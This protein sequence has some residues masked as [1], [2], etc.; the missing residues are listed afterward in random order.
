MRSSYTCATVPR[1]YLAPARRRLSS[2]RR[3]LHL[4][5]PGAASPCV[6]RSCPHAPHS[7]SL[8]LSRRV[9]EAQSSSGMRAA[10][11][12]VSSS[13][14]LR[15]LGVRLHPG[16]RVVVEQGAARL[17]PFAAARPP[18]VV[19]PGFP[20]AGSARCSGCPAGRCHAE[21]VG[22]DH[23]GA[24]AAHEGILASA[25][26]RR[27]GGRGR[28]ALLGLLGKPAVHCLGAFTV[29]SNTLRRA[30]ANHSSSA[31]FSRPRWWSASTSKY[32]FGRYTPALRT[33]MRGR[34]AGARCPRSR[35]GSQSGEGGEA[36]GCRARPARRRARGR[37]DEN[38][39]PTGVMQWASSTTRDR[40]RSPSAFSTN[41]DW[42]LRR[43]SRR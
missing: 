41:A 29:R 5:R 1:P 18:L 32:R 11:V 40:P 24:P 33:R 2:A 27:R 25:R 28:A 34:R 17:L 22:R 20:A 6:A 35:R 12:G 39:C 37:R 3:G 38:R 10:G 19:P 13:T 42:Q 8:R 15:F 30:G 7:R 21:S 26:S 43:A 36:S 14:L 9:L 16:D 4:Q 23:G 31:V